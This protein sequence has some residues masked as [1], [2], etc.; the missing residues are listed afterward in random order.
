[1][2]VPTFRLCQIEAHVRN[3]PSRLTLYQPLT[4]V[5]FPFL[6]EYTVSASYEHGVVLTVALLPS[7]LTRLDI[8]R[9]S[10]GNRRKDD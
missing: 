1:M 3:Y 9:L 5:T 4:R 8:N 6:H 10:T 2:S 7:D